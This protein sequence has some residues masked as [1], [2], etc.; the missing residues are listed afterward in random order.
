MI[1]LCY[2]GSPSAKRAMSLA[3]STIGHHPATV[4]HVWSPPDEFLAAVPF[5]GD[6]A[7]AGSSIVELERLAL[8]RAQAVADEGWGLARGLEFAVESRV[9]RSGGAIWR[10]ILD[11]ADDLDADL[12][13]IGTRGL[14]AIQS[15]LLGSVSNAVIH[16]S[17]RPLL[18]VPAAA[19]R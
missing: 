6:S 4:L 11:A 3:Q 18:V 15:N 5:G 10:T 14:T 17:T 8:D 7:P 1:L 9:E 2:D 13:V 19:S 16:H 12:I